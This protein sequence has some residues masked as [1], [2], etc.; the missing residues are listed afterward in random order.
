MEEKK[1]FKDVWAETKVNLRREIV[2]KKR[3]AVCLTEMFIIA[4]LIVV[5]M[6]TKTYVYGAC[7]KKGKID[8]IS[9]VLSLV[10]VQNTGASFGMLSGKTAY[11]TVVSTICAVFLVFFI[12]YTYKRKNLWLRSALI[13]ITAGA[14][15]NIVDRIALGYVRDFIYFELIDFAVFNFADSCLTVG[16]IVLL[17]YIIFFYGKEEQELA[18]KKTVAAAPTAEEKK[19]EGIVTSEAV[20]DALKSEKKEESVI[21]E[22]KK[23]E[24]DGTI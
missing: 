7:L 21:T 24:E 18:K 16:T 14:I 3:W 8:I 1:A 13:L 20:M 10:P 17:V 19:E 15:G 9:G 5:D 23:E 4:L 12:F 6:L 2:N 11:L 22:E